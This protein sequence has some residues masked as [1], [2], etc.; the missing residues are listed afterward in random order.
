MDV[1]MDNAVVVA[2]LDPKVRRPTLSTL[3]RALPFFCTSKRFPTNALEQFTPSIVPDVDQ[4]VLVAPEVSIENSGFVV[5]AVPPV[6]GVPV[7]ETA[8]VEAAPFTEKML[9]AEN[10]CAMPSNA[11]VPVSSTVSVLLEAPP[12]MVNPVAAAVSVSA[13]TDEGVIAPR[14]NVNAGVVV[15]VATVADTPLAVTTETLVTVPVPPPPP[16]LSAAKRIAFSMVI[17]LTKG[18]TGSV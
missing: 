7:N 18:G 6:K 8:G 3:N 14:V 9:A 17:S 16:P 10:V 13:L 2:P 11:A 4:P 5:V 12:A 15:A 1:I